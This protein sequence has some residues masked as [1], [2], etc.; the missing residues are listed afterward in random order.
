M[1]RFFALAGLIF[2]AYPVLGQNNPG[3]DEFVNKFPLIDSF[4]V[5]IS[6]SDDEQASFGAIAQLD[7][8]EVVEEDSVYFE[9]WYEY[10][11]PSDSFEPIILD[12]EDI[13]SFFKEVIDMESYDPDDHFIAIGQIQLSKDFHTVIYNRIFL[14]YGYESS[15]KHLVTFTPEGDLIS[16]LKVAAMRYGGTGTGLY[17]YRIPWF[18]IDESRLEKNG[19][20]CVYPNQDIRR[21]YQIELDGDIREVE[22]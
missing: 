10:P 6:Y 20:L 18:P 16:S 14:L 11:E 7:S 22:K 3:F 8:M 1:I 19:M 9:Y 5:S 17:G 13:Y 21:C 4:P 2:S 15:E 12:E